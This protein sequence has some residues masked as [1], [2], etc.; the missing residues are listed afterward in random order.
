M[1]TG[2]FIDAIPVG[3]F[4]GRFSRQVLRVFDSRDVVE[5]TKRP[6]SQL[7]IDHKLPRIRW[8]A[9]AEKEQNDYANMSDDDIR[10]KFQ[11]L[12]RSN[13]AV[14][15]NLLKSWTCEG[16]YDTGT[17]GMPFNIRF[18]YS[19]NARWEPESEKDPKGCIGCGWFDFAKWR[20]DLNKLLGGRP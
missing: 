9:E 1:W 12:K 15:H 20:D 13:G 3:V 16:C 2:K 14:S 18:F 19:G 10:D 4:P 17:R 8:D 6:S 7:T 5:M 11:L